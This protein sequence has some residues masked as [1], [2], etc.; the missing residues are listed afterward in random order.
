MSDRKKPAS[1]PPPA[2]V[3]LRATPSPPDEPKL[4]RHPIGTPKGL[5]AN[6]GML[7]VAAWLSERGIYPPHGKPW[8]IEIILDATTHSPM[9][10]YAEAI[11]T[12]FQVTI[13]SD[14]WSFYFCHV[15][16]ISRVRVTD[17]PRAD[18]H[19]DHNLT[20]ATPALKRIGTLLRQ[21][22]QRFGAS[23]Q[24]H[25]ATIITTL[26]GSEPIIRAWVTSL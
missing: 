2:P 21:L 17:L 6:A 4:P 13:C 8:R 15:G 11:D 22:E 7:A 1:E 3:S 10:V 9:R 12:R 24:R 16:R 5:S 23:L 19:D 14:E 25:N 20:S 26:P 18:I